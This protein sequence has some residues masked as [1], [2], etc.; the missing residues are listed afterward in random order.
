MRAS[1]ISPISF[2]AHYVNVDIG[3]SSSLGSMKIRAFDDNG[4]PIDY[5]KTTVFS[6]R[7]IRSEKSFEENVSEKIIAFETRNKDKIKEVDPD[8]EMYLTICYPGPK[9]NEQGKS[10]F[11]LSNF[12]YDD[13]RT[14]RFEKPITPANIDSYIVSRGINIIQTRHVNDMAG[15][16]ACILNKVQEE[17]SDLLEEG[18]EILFLYPGGGLGSGVISVDKH[19][20]KIKPSEVQHA[21]KA[22]AELKPLEA[23]VGVPGFINNF[24]DALDL[25]AEERMLIKG[26]AI[27]A[28]N[29][30][31]AVKHFPEMTKKEHDVAAKYAIDAFMDSLAEVTA[32]EICALKTKSVILTGNVANGNREAVNNNPE[33]VAKEE[34]MQDG[35]DKFTAIFREKVEKNLT[36]VGKIILGNPND[37]DVRFVKLKDNAEGAELLQQC[38]EVGKP[39]KWYNLPTI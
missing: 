3:A 31:E 33:F 30:S 21:R 29:Y 36:Q 28:N 25:S 6:D 26:N 17:H 19:D 10:S 34:Y 2:K 20:V 39:A 11:R 18:N 4:N 37:L 22:T 5:K 14:R 8:N 13:E 7:D 38:E 12:Y 32:M 35:C 16:G 9:T 27:A 1:L 15:A 24:A 23:D